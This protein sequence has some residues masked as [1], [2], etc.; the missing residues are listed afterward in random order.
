MFAQFTKGLKTAVNT[1][2]TTTKSTI[3]VLKSNPTAVSCHVCE[4]QLAVPADSWNWTCAEGH[5]NESDAK[6][7]IVD[8]CSIPQPNPYP[9]PSVQCPDCNVSTVVPKTNIQKHLA[10]AAKTTKKAA[11]VAKDTTV[12]TYNHLK[13]A[14]AQFHCKHCDALLE[15]PQG[16]WVCQKCSATNE[17]GAA[18]CATAECP[19]KKADQLAQCGLCNKLTNIP[20]TNLM[21]SI[22]HGISTVKMGAKTAYYFVGKKPNVRC[23]QCNEYVEVPMTGKD[24]EGNAVVDI[25]SLPETLPCPK[26]NA[27]VSTAPVSAAAVEPVEAAVEAPATEAAAAAEAQ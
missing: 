2:V 13:S 11:I 21:N 23:H 26:C 15:V 3:N 18:C 8:T 19:Q 6:I 20:T 25:A 16:P 9:S 10:T 7:C 4:K 1:A 12:A 24:A 22:T 14:P 27:A 17:E 5:V